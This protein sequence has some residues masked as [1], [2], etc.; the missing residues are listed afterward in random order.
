MYYLVFFQVHSTF[1]LP[2]KTATTS[3]TTA[4]TTAA[5]AVR[6]NRE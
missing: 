1:P 2:A 6:E 4:T 5:A 3:T